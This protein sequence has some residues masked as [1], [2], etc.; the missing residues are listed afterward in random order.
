MFLPR[1]HAVQIPVCSGQIRNFGPDPTICK[2]CK[3]ILIISNDNFKFFTRWILII[4]LICFV[5][6]EKMLSCFYLMYVGSTA[7]RKIFFLNIC[8]D[9]ETFFS[10]SNSHVGTENMGSVKWLLI[11]SSV[12]VPFT[13]P[14]FW[15]RVNID[16]S[17]HILYTPGWKEYRKYWCTQ[18]GPCS[19]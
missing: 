1:L 12:C 18:A 19:L 2:I 7:T 5:F 15:W 14:T 16:P 3:T 4:E 17:H 6:I 10:V 9:S 8:R 11:N 13:T